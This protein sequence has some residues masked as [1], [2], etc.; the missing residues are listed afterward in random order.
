MHRRNFIL[1]SIAAGAL[2]GCK[3]TN[4]DGTAEAVAPPEPP[5]PTPP[6]VTPP[7]TTPPPT[8]P[9]P[10]TPPP[11]TPPPTTPPPT[12]PPPTTPP[13]TPPPPTPEPA[14]PPSGT[15]SL[16]AIEFDNN[17]G[18][19]LSSAPWPMFWQTSYATND[20][21]LIEWGTGDHDQFGDNGVREFDPV[22]KTQRYVYPNNNGTKDVQQYDNQQYWYIPR[23]DSL[24]IPGRGQYLRSQQKWVR[25]GASL[26]GFW[27]N[28]PLVFGT[29]ANDLMRPLD[30]NIQ[31]PF[32]NMYNAHQAWS[33]QQD[34]GV[35]IGGSPG[36]DNTAQQTL[37]MVVPSQGIGNY[38]QPYVIISRSM[39]A[40]VSGEPAHSLH[41]RDGCCFHGEYV[42]WVGGETSV[43][44]NPKRTFFRMWMNPHLTSTSAPLSIERLPDLPVAAGWCLLR[45]DPYT[46]A[47]LC[48]CDGGLFAF[49]VKGWTWTDVTPQGYLSD[50]AAAP[51][52]GKLPKGCLGDFINTSGGQTLRKFYWRPGIDHAWDYDDSGANVNRLYRRFRSIKLARRP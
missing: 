50:Y 27:P 51:S 35:M 8:T 36:G 3:S 9:P 21:T 40:T 25:G 10:T 37:Y 52:N 22:S 5:P 33:K 42:Y 1:T 17:V 45:S 26:G 13:P 6:P 12:T 7:P 49:D 44:R 18:T 39:P 19:A 31:Y 32:T 4:P 11:T 14:P 41:G 28:G 29:G 2:A 23:L 34:C 20:G 47:L 48:V 15:G 30:P 16:Y 46:D 43:N 24:V 38:P